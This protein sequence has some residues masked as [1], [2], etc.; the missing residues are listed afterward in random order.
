[1]CL[2]IVFSSTV[3]SVGGGILAGI[4]LTLALNKVMASWAAESS[5]DPLMLSRGYLSSCLW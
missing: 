5:R 2:R 4:A 1:M 3:L